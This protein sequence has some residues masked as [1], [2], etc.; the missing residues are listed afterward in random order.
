M[1]R[2]SISKSD[3][4]PSFGHDIWK[5]EET[6]RRRLKPFL[7]CRG[8]CGCVWLLTLWAR[9]RWSEES[10]YKTLPFTWTELSCPMHH[11]RPTWTQGCGQ[12]CR[13]LGHG[14]C[15][16]GKRDGGFCAACSEIHWDTLCARHYSEAICQWREEKDNQMQTRSSVQSGPAHFLYGV[17][18]SEITES[19]KS[20]WSLKTPPSSPGWE[21]M[22]NHVC[23]GSR[24]E[25]QE[26]RQVSGRLESRASLL[27]VVMQAIPS[28]L[29]GTAQWE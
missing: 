4:L 20:R 13:L 12:L 5:L 27:C 28:P 19:I 7:D 21:G 17:R 3:F 18:T 1:S 22:F 8:H 15:L 16:L 26:G 10:R 14:W 11:L 29:S 6:S 23:S 2:E 9:E 25:T 24:R